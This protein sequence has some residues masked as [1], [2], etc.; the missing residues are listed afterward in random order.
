MSR[1]IQN[2]FLFNDENIK[3]IR[4]RMPRPGEDIII[5]ENTKIQIK[6]NV[7]KTG[8]YKRL[9]VPK[10]SILEFMEPNITLHVE[11]SYIMG[12]VEFDEN[13]LITNN[14]TD[15]VY[16]KIWN[17]DESWKG[18]NNNNHG[19]QAE[20]EFSGIPKNG[21]PIWIPENTTIY[22]TNDTNLS[23]NIYSELY[24]PE[25]SELIFDCSNKVLFV[26]KLITRGSWGTTGIN[27]TIWIVQ[28]KMHLKVPIYLDSKKEILP[29]GILDDEDIEETLDC[30][31]NFWMVADKTTAKEF[32]NMLNYKIENEEPKFICNF[33]SR[34][35]C[36]LN[37]LHDISNQ[38]INHNEQ[39]FL[40][41][42]VTAP[43]TLGQ[44]F[45]Q[46]ISDI[47][48]GI[49]KTSGIISNE[50]EIIKNIINSDLHIQLTSALT[51]GL[52]ETDLSENPIINSLLKQLKFNK[53]DRFLGEKKN[54]LYKIPI[55]KGDNMSLFIKMSG[56]LDLDDGISIEKYNS[57][58]DL[59]K[60]ICQENTVNDLI[61]FNDAKKQVHFSPTVWRL[62]INLN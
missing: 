51:Y 30:S 24:I 25:T 23:N 52:N 54:V 9:V 39:M 49:P 22:I 27:N 58:Y 53:P 32:S 37:L 4:G 12:R 50:K 41:K 3:W 31:Y 57:K 26:E 62:E 45:I 38:I 36:E 33:E 28:G 44:Y 18:G 40:S 1:M 60:I 55:I 19:N 61:V 7:I 5:P 16:K 11:Q 43:G 56:V 13:C 6:K 20:N 2:I 17:N 42:N 14:K 48:F 10:T 34:I 59:L 8:R 47:L 46:Y 21:N 29:L 35:K 15:S